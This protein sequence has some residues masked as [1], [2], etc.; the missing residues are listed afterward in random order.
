MRG[1]AVYQSMFTILTMVC[2]FVLLFS[3]IA[4]SNNQGN[5]GLFEVHF[6]MGLQGYQFSYICKEGEICPI[7]D[8][9]EA[10]GYDSDMCR[11]DFCG[12]C[13]QTTQR[14]QAMIEACL[15]FIGLYIVIAAIRGKLRNKGGFFGKLSGVAA[16]AVVLLMICSTWVLWIA[17]CANH[18]QG[19]TY[20]IGHVRV[21]NV[22]PQL[23]YGFVVAT[24]ATVTAFLA[25]LVEICRRDFGPRRNRQRIPYHLIAIG[26]TVTITP[27]N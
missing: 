24:L 26:E 19:M 21:V 5:V 17:K 20:M 9:S 16:A 22:K 8:H 1:R 2:A 25:I 15:G 3:G 12:P 10:Q 6:S 27:N 11:W 4:W 14:M 23:H 18:F 7:D 13:K